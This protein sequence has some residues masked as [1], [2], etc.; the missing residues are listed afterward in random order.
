VE[1]IGR[2]EHI[3]PED[4]SSFYDLRG[5][6]GVNGRGEILHILKLR[7]LAGKSGQD[8]AGRNDGSIDLLVDTTIGNRSLM[9]MPV[10]ELLAK[11]ELFA[12]V[13][14]MENGDLSILLDVESLPG[15]QGRVV[16]R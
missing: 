4:R 7:H 11:V 2:A 5:L 1:S 13:G 15:V 9:V 6:L 10:G 16:N 8:K 14:I 12:G 3:S